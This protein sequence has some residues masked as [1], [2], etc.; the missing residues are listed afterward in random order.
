MAVRR[1]GRD[2]RCVPLAPQL[3]AA[4]RSLGTTLYISRGGCGG[5]CR[6]ERGACQE[7]VIKTA[8]FGAPTLESDLYILR[9]LADTEHD[10]ARLVLQHLHGNRTR[11][12][13]VL[14]ISRTT[15]WR[16]LK[17]NDR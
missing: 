16:L 13:E 2:A 9:P 4:A 1:C 6:G 3:P 5:A 14:G 8:T 10:I 7:D 15:L 12:A 17:D 11:A